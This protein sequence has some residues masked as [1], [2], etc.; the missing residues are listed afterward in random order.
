MDTE[1]V[2]VLPNIAAAIGGV[3]AIAIGVDSV[4]VEFTNQQRMT[5]RFAR[6]YLRESNAAEPGLDLAV[7]VAQ[8]AAEH[9]RPVNRRITRLAA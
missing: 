3:A 1:T 4:D 5:Q 2:I 8:L 6:K 7:R 9:G